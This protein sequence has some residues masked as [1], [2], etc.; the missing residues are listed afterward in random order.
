MK[1]QT[2]RDHGQLKVDIDG[3]L[4]A[5]LSFKSFRPNPVNVSEFYQA[6]VRLFSVLSSGIINA[7]GVPYSRFGESWIGDGVYDFSAVDRQIEMFIQAAPDGYFA[8][9]FQVDTRPWYLGTHPEALNSFTHL[10]WSAC[11]EAWK[12][13]AAEYLKA[14]IRHCEET[15]GDRIYGYFILG[16]M[17]TEW[18]AHPDEE[19]SHPLKEAAYRQYRKDPKAA[20]PDRETLQRGG[21]VFL[22]GEEENVYYARRFHAETVADLILYFAGEAQSVLRHQ[23]LLGLYYGYLM[24]LGGEFLFNSGHLAYEKVFL[25]PDIDMISSPSDYS[26]RALTDPSAFMVT[27]KTLDRHGKLYFLE[28]D[29]ITHVAPTMIHEPGNDPSGNECLREIPGAR[30]KCRNETES[31]NLMWRDYILCYANGAAMWWFDMFD[32]WFR[33]D[34]MMRAVS[35]MTELH[36]TLSDQKKES[37]A[38]IGIY[39]EGDSMYHVR[40]TSG[41]A[42]VGLNDMQRSFA[43]MGAPCDL[44]SAADLDEEESGKYRLIILLNLYEIPAKRMRKIRSLQQA[45]VTV[46]W[47]YAPDYANGGKNDVARLS[48]AVGMK[49]SESCSTHG[50]LVWNGQ[51]FANRMAAP[52]FAIADPDSL[53]LA[54]FEDGTVAAAIAK[55]GKSIYAAVP[56]LPSAILREIA[57]SCGV[58]LYS[59]TP[60]VYTYVNADAVGVYNATEEA[61]QIFVRED[62]IYRD[63]IEG[64][65]YESHN[66]VLMLPKKPLR[67]WLLTRES[68]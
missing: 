25:S 20:L 40:K 18:L 34:A 58:F 3:R 7:L 36:E 39:A 56:F 45:G 4:F 66:N 15:Y 61:A 50:G 60:R 59:E 33:S 26:Y 21:N 29:H 48:E 55:D 46:L 30:N 37:V 23:K 10:S 16:G 22:S 44:Y 57:R 8:P 52:Y 5:P 35:H 1:V 42:S 24:H 17:T 68:N 14:V 28:F 6:G 12:K 32:G 63:Q 31:L 43:E 54:Y 49:V 11:D 64:G 47:M 62:G 13:D 2:R 41:L 51:V 27:Q 53:P 67:A 65:L 19:A 9:M 38:E